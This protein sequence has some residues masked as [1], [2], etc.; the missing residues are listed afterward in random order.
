MSQTSTHPALRFL[1]ATRTVTGSRFLV[2]TSDRRILVD[3]GLFQGL[4]EDRERNWKPF[5]I[6]PSDIDAVVLTHAHIDHSG[7]LPAL[8]RDGFSGPIV[9]SDDTAKLCEILLRDAA[10]LQEEEARYANEAGY[11]KHHPA[12]PLYTREDAEAVLPMFTPHALEAPID[13]GGGIMVELQWAGH[14]LGAASATVDLLAADGSDRRVFFSGDIGRPTHPLLEPPADPPDADVFVVESTY[15]DRTH[16][17][18]EA[19]MQRL[20]AAINGAAD[21]GGMVVIPAFAVD[22]TEVV[23]QALHEL[24]TAERIPRLPIHVDSPMALSVLG[25]YRAAIAGNDSGIRSDML[26]S[27]PFDTSRI[28][29]CRTTQE[30]MKLAELTYPSI[31]ISASGMA[32]GGRVLHHLARLLPDP[33]NAVILTGFQAD[34]TR[35][36]RLAGGERAVKMFGHYIPVR[37]QVEVIQSFSV[38]ADADEIVAWLRRAPREPQTCFLV[39]GNESASRAL[40]DR[41]IAELGWCVAVPR[42]MERVLVD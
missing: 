7:Y 10:H 1:G 9:T 6:S 24:E 17:P 30:S 34:G 40:Q 42:R 28:H 37:A 4:K 38:H 22:R 36:Q 41:V 15:G 18:A 31:I 13:I 32:T 11:S 39:H 16:P 2:E 26:G 5:P 25:L 19:E 35:G 3:C 8:V 29:E 21:R 27:S 23:L 20:A 14:I 12:L 33:A